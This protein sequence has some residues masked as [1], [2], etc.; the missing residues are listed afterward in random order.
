MHDSAAVFSGEKSHVTCLRWM[1]GEFRPLSSCCD[2]EETD[3]LVGIVIRP[4]NRGSRPG[5]DEIFFS[6]LKPANRL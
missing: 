3:S 4:N 6:S 1:L 5:R 2:G